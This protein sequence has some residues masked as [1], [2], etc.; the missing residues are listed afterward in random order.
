[1]T[2][3]PDRSRRPSSTYRVQLRPE[4]GFAEVAELAPYLEELGIS[5]LYASPSFEA[6]P[7]STHGYDVVDPTRPSDALGGEPAHRLLAERLAERGLGQILDIVPNHMAIGVRENGWWWDVLENG[8]SSVFASY[9]D[10]DWDPAG[11]VANRVLLPVLPDHYGRVLEAGGLRLRRDGAEV[12]VSGEGLSFPLSPTSCAEL[13]RRAASTASGAGELLALA[14]ALGAL[15]PSWVTDAPS[16]RSRHR[17]KERLRGQ[18]EELLRQRQDLAGAVDGVLEATS[19]DPDALDSVLEQQNYR[20]AHWRSAG[21]ELEYR[22][23][24]D[25]NTLIGLRVEDELVFAD[26]HSR[27]LEWLAEGRIDGLRVDHVDGLADPGAYLERLWN[28]SRGAWVVVEKILAEGEQLPRHWP[29]AGT[30]GYEVAAALTRVFVAPGAEQPLVEAWAAIS[31]DDRPFAEVAHEAK[32]E[33]LAGS[34]ASDLSRVGDLTVEVARAHRRWRD[35]TPPE[36]REA[37]EE[38]CCCLGVYRTYVPPSGHAADTDRARLAASAQEALRRRPTLD[39]ELLNRF[40]LPLLSGDAP[41]V[42]EPEAAAR[43]RFQ[44]LTGPV[45]AKGVEDRAFY[46]YLVL[47]ALNEVGAD[48]GRFAMA[49][50]ALHEL[51][52]SVQ[53]GWPEQL[54]TGSTHDTKRSE[55]VRARLVGISE[56]PERWLDAVGRFRAALGGAWQSVAPDPLAEYLLAQTIVGAWPIGADRL[57]AYLHKATREAGLRT[58]WTDPDADY[59]AAIERVVQFALAGP[60]SRLEELVRG[61]LGPSGR[62]T[63]LAMKAVQ[64][65]APGVPDTYQGTECWELSL[66]DPD[67]R[68]PVDYSLRREL[69]ERASQEPAQAW[70]RREAEGLPKLGLTRAVLR[71]RRAHPERFGEAAAY[72]PLA[73]SGPAAAHA[74]GFLRGEAVAVVVPRLVLTLCG[75]APATSAASLC[76]RVAQALVETVVELPEGPWRDLCTGASL[77]GGVVDVGDLLRDFPVAVLSLDG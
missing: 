64:L 61:W 53:S 71:E 9:F 52:Q 45:A 7:G 50:E 34:L 6:A 74:M 68:R 29:V 37:C 55:D 76:G 62:I 23:F 33:V 77:G 63:S 41:F 22:R 54:V 58:S 8:P 38:L 12:T 57:V 26:S 31:G 43:R 66:V 16:V 21:T 27:A 24:F 2:P 19:A 60:A 69:A 75:S 51:L 17:D 11:G 25:I 35:Y 44:Q 3:A 40:L 65:V 47:G 13:L 4:L 48:P 67:N 73:P 30:T 32:H 1:M 72:R 15:P 18:L 20:L 56:M 10:V 14:Q 28:A 39:A 59:D 5:H 36:I 49:P 42:G 46:R 70:W